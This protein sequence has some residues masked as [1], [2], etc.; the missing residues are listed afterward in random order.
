MTPLPEATPLLCARTRSTA[1]GRRTSSVLLITFGL[2][3]AGC[4][5]EAGPA[6]FTLDGSR[7]TLSDGDSFRIG[8]ARYR[9]WGIDAPELTQRCRD[10]GGR[11]YRC[12]QE[13]K[14]HLA[15]LIKGKQLECTRKD[16]DRY[17]RVVAVCEVD[18]NDLGAAMVES[19]HAFDLARYSGGHYAEAQAQAQ[20]T[21]LGIWR[22]RFS[23]PWEW[24]KDN[25]RR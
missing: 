1:L 3:L 16:E 15:Q 8:D 17:G 18:G 2:T 10:E 23:W 7:L 22:G 6:S 4:A 5:E 11:E 13:S 14:A 12:G 19:G 21:R 9:L 20:K 24:R 25:Q